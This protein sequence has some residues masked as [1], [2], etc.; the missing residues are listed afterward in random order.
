MEEVGG[1]RDQNP[2]EFRVKG[3]RRF[4][5]WD[6]A[7][8]GVWSLLCYPLK[9]QRAASTGVCSLTSCVTILSLR[10]SGER[11]HS[12]L[13]AH[14]ERLFAEAEEEEYEEVAA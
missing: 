6:G 3:L 14:C 7:S 8:S 4:W 1:S 12:S 11:I 2:S 10:I 5:S 9:P 13:T